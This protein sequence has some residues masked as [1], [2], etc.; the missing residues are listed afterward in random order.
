M[1]I[2]TDAAPVSPATAP[3]STYLLAEIAFG[4]IAIPDILVHENSRY[5]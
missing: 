5:H 2:T 3:A 4:I 1:S